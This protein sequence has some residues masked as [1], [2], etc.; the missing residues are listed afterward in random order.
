MCGR[1]VGACA[2]NCVVTFDFVC[3]KKATAKRRRRAPA[4]IAT[5][6]VRPVADSCHRHPG[7]ERRKSQHRRAAVAAYVRVRPCRLRI[8]RTSV[9]RR[10]ER[11]RRQRRRNGANLLRP[12]GELCG[13]RDKLFNWRLICRYC[14]ISL[15]V[16]LHQQQHRRRPQ[17]PTR[18]GCSSKF[19]K[20]RTRSLSNR[21]TKTATY[22]MI[23]VADQ[24]IIKFGSRCY[25]NAYS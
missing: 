11:R 3:R 10:L 6:A 1:C 8:S 13:T 7:P 18:I 15:V 19:E 25:S 23:A 14:S 17:R 20:V 21:K 24:S 9:R 4:R 16:A 22:I 2:P 5:A 12:A